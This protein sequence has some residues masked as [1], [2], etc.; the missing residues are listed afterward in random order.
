MVHMVAMTLPPKAG[1]VWANIAT[2]PRRLWSRIS[3]P[4]QSAVK[5]QPN[6]YEIMGARTRP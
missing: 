1:R 2:S 6:R 3:N 5:P 4:V